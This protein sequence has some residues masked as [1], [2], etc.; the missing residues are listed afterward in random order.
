MSFL[1]FA[2]GSNLLR[3]RLVRANPSAKFVAVAKLMV[4]IIIY[5]VTLLLSQVRTKFCGFG[6]N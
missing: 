5:A 6:V 1:Y 4:S 2:Y 3:E